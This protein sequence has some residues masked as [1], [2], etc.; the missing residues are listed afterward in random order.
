M[1]VCCFPQNLSRLK[2]VD[3]DILLPGL[4]LSDEDTELLANEV[5][6]LAV[7]G[8]LHTAVSECACVCCALQ[9]LS[10]LRAVDGDILL[11]G[12][13]LSDGDTELLAEEVGSF[14]FRLVF[15]LFI[16]FIFFNFLFGLLL[17]LTDT[18]LLANEV[19]SFLL[20]LINIFDM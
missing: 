13:G 6:H 17:P 16:K 10:R 18:E 14:L 4:G 5:S 7:Y 12:L 3:G 2:A 19:R 8:S 15:L 20:P 11:P 9:N 1:C